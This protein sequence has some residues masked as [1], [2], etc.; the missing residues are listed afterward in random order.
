MLG[1]AV[2]VFDGV[3][4][5]DGV[6]WTAMISSFMQARIWA[7]AVRCYA[8]MMDDFMPPNGYSFVKLSVACGFLGIERVKAIHSQLILWGVRLNLVLK[9]ALVDAYVRCQRVEEALKVLKQTSEEDVQLWTTVMCGFARNMSFSDG[10]AAFRRMLGSNIVPRGYCYVGIL[11]ACSSS[12]AMSLGK[13]IH[14]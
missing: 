1:D 14:A 9:T 2:R 4:N 7:R 3:A 11:N 6:C 12:R 13:Q 10:V 8:R 5:A